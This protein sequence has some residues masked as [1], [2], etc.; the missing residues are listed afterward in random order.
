MDNLTTNGNPEG[1]R[2]LVLWKEFY[3]LDPHDLTAAKRFITHYRLIA[4]A[5]LSRPAKMMLKALDQGIPMPVHPAWG[6]SVRRVPTARH[7]MREN[8]LLEYHPVF[9]KTVD[10]TI[11][12]LGNRIGGASELELFERIGPLNGMLGSCHPR[13]VL[14]DRNQR[15]VLEMPGSDKGYITTGD[16]YFSFVQDLANAKVGRC[17][18]DRCGRIFAMTG[19][20]RAQQSKG[21]R[22]FCSP[23][24]RIE[25]HESRP[26]RR[27]QKIA[28]AMKSKKRREKRSNSRGR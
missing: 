18:L 2:D 1:T 12:W 23:V 5:D 15:L 19:K 27:A 26:E 10:E 16:I 20:Q 13:L 28:S 17:A 24:H 21:H 11:K 14:D 22:I 8:A 9:V 6:M 7:L 25:F 4:G 3:D